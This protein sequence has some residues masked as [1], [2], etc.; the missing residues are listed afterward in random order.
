MAE[1]ELGKW[2]SEELRRPFRSR[3]IGAAGPVGEGMAALIAVWIVVDGGLRHGLPTPPCFVQSIRNR[4]LS[5]DLPG[6]EQQVTLKTKSPAKGRAFGVCFY[7]S[8]L[9]ETALPLWGGI[10]LWWKWFGL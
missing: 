6:G 9:R 8:G 2:R 3:G 10:F 7:F 4:L 5:L 1:R